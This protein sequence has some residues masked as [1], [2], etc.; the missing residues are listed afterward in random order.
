LRQFVLLRPVSVRGLDLNVFDCD[1]DLTWYALMLSPDGAVL[2]RFGGR[3]ADTPGKYHSLKGLRYSLEQALAR[4]RRG[5]VP[6]PSK[7]PPVRAEDYPAAKQ[8]TA[9]SCVHCHH[10]YE[11]RRDAQQQSGTWKLDELWVYPQ[12]QNVG[13]TL[14]INE[15]NRVN[16]VAPNSVAGRAGLR[17]GDVLRTINGQPVASIADVQHALHRAPWD[18][19]LPLA[20]LREGRPMEGALALTA[21]WKKTDLS[22][23]RSVKTLSPSLGVM[24][25][26]LTAE[27]KARLGLPPKALAFRQ[28]A[29]LT[30]MASQAGVRVGD[31]I[32]GVNEDRPAMTARQFETFIRLTFRAGDT[33]T[34]HVWRGKDRLDLPLKLTK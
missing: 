23:R 24:G 14:D 6:A 7:A 3:D 29:Y 16:A 30:P 4:Y 13:V 34:L 22:W 9:K 21:G 15:G 32:V 18:G 27:E 12:P 28:M 10:V 33:V 2:G 25:D 31:I 20:W 19:R 11:F 17:S 5:D 26:D 8:L 1:Y